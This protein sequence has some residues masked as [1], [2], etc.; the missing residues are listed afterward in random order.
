VYGWADEIL[1]VDDF[2]T[3][4]TVEIG[5]RYATKILQRATDVEGK[6]RNWACA[7]A[8]NGWILS[9]DADECA[10]PQLCVEISALLSSTPACV[11]YDIPRKNFVGK[12]WIRWG[13]AY[14]ANQLRFFRK[15]KLRYEEVAVHPRMFL[16]G[17]CGHLKSD[18]IHYSWD[19]IAEM[20]AKVNGQTTLEAQKWVI[21]GRKMSAGRAAWRTID[22]FF[23]RFLSRK[24]YKDGYIGFMYALQDSLYQALSYVKYRDILERKTSGK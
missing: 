7:L 18:M 17:P 3:D 8:A 4:K 20:V 13:G 15:D 22:R 9:L 11:G 14:P 2:S 6:Q 23:R 10:T 24:G 19:D 1:L 21:M 12:Y 16:D 5:Q